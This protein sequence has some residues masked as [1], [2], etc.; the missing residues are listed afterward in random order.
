MWFFGGSKPNVSGRDFVKVRNHLRANG[1][2]R[3][4]ADR[5][6]EIFR[7]DMEEGSGSQSGIDRPEIDRGV[8]WLRE[9]KEKHHLSDEQIGIVEETLRK[10]L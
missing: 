3:H 2:S 6:E 7:G 8:K 4:D 10:H 9:N 5:V 1:F